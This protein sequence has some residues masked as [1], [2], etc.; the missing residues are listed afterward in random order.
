MFITSTSTNLTKGYLPQSLIKNKINQKVTE[1]DKLEWLKKGPTHCKK[2]L[3]NKQAHIK[4]MKSIQKNRK[5]YRTAT[6][7]LSGHA[8]LNNHLFKMRLTETKSCESCGEEN[9]TVE[10]FLGKCPALYN[11]RLEIFHT[12]I[13]NAEEVFNHPLSKI[14]R[15]ANKTK[16]MTFDPTTRD[17][18][19]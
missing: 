6:Q 17:G 16:R 4:S 11:T 2:A 12:H 15:F 5:D 10:H 19:T 3:N 14:I 1:L 18:V 7:L 9:E 8:G 13:I